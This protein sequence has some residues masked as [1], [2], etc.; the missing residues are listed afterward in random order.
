MT[1]KEKQNI[2]KIVQESRAQFFSSADY[3]A[4]KEKDRIMDDAL[5]EMK[6]AI[7]ENLDWYLNPKKCEPYNSVSPSISPSISPSKRLKI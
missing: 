4:D 2:L 3:G 6:A 5:Y 7:Y 1:A